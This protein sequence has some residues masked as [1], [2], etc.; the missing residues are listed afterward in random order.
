[1]MFIMHSLETKNERTIWTAIWE[2]ADNESKMVFDVFSKA[3]EQKQKEN[4]K[5]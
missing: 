2:Y 1:M 5:P 3:W 4:E